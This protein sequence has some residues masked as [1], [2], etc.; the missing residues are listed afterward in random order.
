[1]ILQLVIVTLVS[2][3]MLGDSFEATGYCYT[4]YVHVSVVKQVPSYSKHCTKVGFN[5]PHITIKNIA[6]RL[7][8]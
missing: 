8:M 4:Q 7:M 1:M 3:I 6:A 5:F 2:P